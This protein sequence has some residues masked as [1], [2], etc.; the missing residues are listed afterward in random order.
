MYP[1]PKRELP[2]PTSKVPTP[3]D[4]EIEE[5]FIERPPPGLLVAVV[6][7]M[8]GVDCLNCGWIVRRYLNTELNFL[9]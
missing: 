5:S 8:E 6:E 4:S 3:G 1:P 2:A 9:L 7:W